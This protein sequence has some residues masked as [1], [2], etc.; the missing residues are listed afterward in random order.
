ME[1]DS[2]LS[3]GISG[4]MKETMME[5]SDKSQITIDTRTGFVPHT[6]G[7]DTTEIQVPHA[8]HLMLNELKTM[9]IGA[10]VETD[11]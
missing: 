9:S 2:I 6:H 7:P 5:R 8:F 10:R 1:R 3:H 11:S 4:F